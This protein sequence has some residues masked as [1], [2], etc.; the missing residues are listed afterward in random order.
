M[1]AS[2]FDCYQTL[3]GLRTLA[4]RL[5]AAEKNALAIAKY[6]EAQEAVTQVYYPGLENDAGYD[7]ARKQQCGAGPML[8]FEV[9]G[10]LEAARRFCEAL[11]IFGLAASLGGVESLICLPETMTHRGMEETARRA[12]G[13][14]D[15]LLRV[16]VGIESE[17]DL[18]ADLETGFSAI[19]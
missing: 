18:L 16:S 19:I 17:S 5:D 1:T 13:I 12:A 14:S 3:R 4:L 2:A 7:L 9:K 11:N 10:G 6:L 8:S 15:S